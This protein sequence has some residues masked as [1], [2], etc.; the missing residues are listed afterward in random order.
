L[1]LTLWIAIIFAGRVI[2]F[3][4]TGAQAREAPPPPATN[5]DDFLTGG[6][7]TPAPPAPATPSS[8]PSNQP[9]TDPANYSIRTIMAAMVDPSADFLCE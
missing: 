2:G 3:T 6:P 1:S 5:F 7:D 9:S 4:T 8:A